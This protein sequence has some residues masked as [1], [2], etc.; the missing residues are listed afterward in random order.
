VSISLPADIAAQVQAHLATGQFA[1][2][3]QVLREALS[4]LERRQRSMA[5]LKELLRVAEDDVAAGRLAPFDRDELK[6]EVR[7]KL[8]AQGVAE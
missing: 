6:R 4:T 8:A 1:S 2:E 3:E 5:Y 7:A